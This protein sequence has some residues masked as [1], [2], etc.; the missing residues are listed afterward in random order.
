MFE[1]GSR[2]RSQPP[3]PAIVFA[4]LTEPDRDRARPWLRLLDDERAPRILHAER[5]HLVVWSSLWPR[6][7]EAQI[8]FDLEPDAG[9]GTQLR[10]TLL[11]A[12]PLPDASLLGH[13][14]KRLNQLINAELRYTFGQ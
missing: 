2:V 8:R 11:A 1:V 9:G 12:E 5:P 4:A 14:R 13:L 10:W 3:P 7:P 6:R